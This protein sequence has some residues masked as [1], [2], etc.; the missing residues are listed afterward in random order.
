MIEPWGLTIVIPCIPPK[1]TAQQKIVDKRGRQFDSSRLS[2]AKKSFVELLREHLP[3]S[4]IEGAISVEITLVWP[5]TQKDI[6]TRKKEA[7]RWGNGACLPHAGYP[8]LDNFFKAFFDTMKTMGF[9]KDDKAIFEITNTR[10]LR[11]QY[12]GMVLRLQNL[13]PEI[14]LHDVEEIEMLQKEWMKNDK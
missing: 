2:N 13:D 7:A 5:Y 4:P 12:P 14:E 3:S 8:D 11:G 6:S 9:F 1:V 10:K